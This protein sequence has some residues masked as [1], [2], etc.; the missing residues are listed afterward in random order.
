MTTIN[1]TIARLDQAWND[2]DAAAY[3]AAFTPDVAHAVIGAGV[4]LDGQQTVP[5]DRASVVSLVL[6]AAAD[7]EWLITAFQ[8]TRRGPR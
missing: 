7:G 6:V 8:N 1:D 4:R 3:A 5:T 2:A